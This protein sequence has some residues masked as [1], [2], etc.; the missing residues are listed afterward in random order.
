MKK[1]LILFII[2]INLIIMNQLRAEEVRLERIVVTPYKVATSSGAS[3]TDIFSVD[4]L[5]A[6][7]IFTLTDAIEDI[8]SLSHSTTGGIGG[9][10][11]VYIRGAD[12]SHT[13]VLL[14]GI[15]LNDPIAPSGYFHGYNH[16]SLDNI[17]R[18]E[19]SKGP[20]SSLY[21]S[22]S[23]GGTISL[24][25]HKGK[26]KPRFSY[27]QEVGSYQ[28]YREKLSSQGEIDKLAYSFSVSKTDVNAFYAGKDK[29]G[30]HEKDPYRNLS[31]SL[32]LDYSLTDDIDIGLIT[33]YTYA[34][35]EYDGS[36]GTDD[37]DNYARFYQGVG[38]FNIKQTLSDTLSH[39]ATLGYT[40]TYRNGW[41]SATS[42]NWYNGKTYQVK[43]QGDYQ[44]CDFDKVIFG[45]DYLRERG[46]SYWAPTRNPNK[47]ANTKGYYIEN[48]FTPI[49]DLFIAAS[50]R[51]EDHSS[52]K[53][54]N[55]FTISG[56]YLIG[57]TGTKIKGSYGEGF[58]APSLYQLYDTSS[59]NPDL[60]P[61][62]SENYEAGFEQKLGNHLTLGSTYFHTYLKNLIE[63]TQTGPNWWDGSYSNI[64]K[65]RIY[66][67]E[68]FIRYELSDNTS[69]D[70]SYTHM[71]TRDKSNAQRLSWRPDNK[72]TCNLK[73]AFDKLL[74]YA[75]LSYVGNRLD[76]SNKLKSYI[77]G[78]VTFNYGIS[79]KM[80]IFLRLENILDKDYELKK[81]YQMPEFSWYL[82]AKLTF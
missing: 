19:V 30:N 2:I 48:I 6:Q 11:G 57:Q 71:N 74:M 22:D 61:E 5:N 82:G 44:L 3:S 42:D 52:Y 56:S 81:G 40:R 62:E 1:N 37:F 43:W 14:D 53:H 10:T 75:S 65:A 35:Y 77:L 78:N 41:E 9:V 73:T 79:E 13:Q 20:Y 66:G 58:K 36:G 23:I 50:Y 45:F 17:E 67:I 59:G 51:L 39:K 49:D 31:S 68:N 4:E 28:T 47:T 60:N 16:I 27:T 26:G 76:G 70:F 80:D 25:T 32:R 38:A 8:S 33:D 18:I 15:K 46:E 64:G 63:W 12:S 7:G 34:K 29:N 69:I 55:I 24:M 21:G 72:M 54:H